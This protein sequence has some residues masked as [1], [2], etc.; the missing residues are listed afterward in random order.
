MN[1]TFITGNP[2]KAEFLKKY[3]GVELSHQKLDLDELQSLSLREITEHKVKQAFEL[4]QGPVLI[5]DIGFSIMA[6][7]RLPG[8][9]IKWFIGE[10]GF[11]KLCRLADADPSRL[12]ETSVCYAYFDGAR[13]EFFE[14]SQKGILPDHPRGDDGFGW[15]GIFIPEGQ[16]KTIAEMDETEM[17]KYSLRT[18]T[19]YPQIK[20]FLAT[21]DN[22]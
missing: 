1:V 3:L 9:F 8:P 10:I 17:E 16:G 7:R 6:M 13:L 22:S 5:E 21:L 12:A 2:K 4:V 19:V 11:E 14:G 15:N 18:T 20:K